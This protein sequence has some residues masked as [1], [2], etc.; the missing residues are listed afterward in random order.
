MKAVSL[1]LLVTLSVIG[2]FALFPARREI[3][4]QQR[5]QPGLAFTQT[6][7]VD[8]LERRALIYPNRAPAPQ[9]GTPMV[10]IFHGHGG[11]MRHSARRFAIHTHWPQAIVAYMQ[12]LPTAGKT[13]PEGKRA[14][15]QHQPDTLDNRDVKF[16][17]VVLDWARSNYRIDATRIYA[18]GHSNGAAMTYVLWSVRGEVLAAVAPSAAAFGFGVRSATPKPALIIAG[19]GDH[20]VPTNMQKLNM[21]AVLKRNQCEV[22]GEAWKVGQ[23]LY[24]SKVGADVATYVHTNG[25]K[26]PD[27]TG[28]TMVKF[29]QRYAL[30]PNRAG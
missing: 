30:K 26:M 6:F 14:G 3:R 19:E 1:S 28:V 16:F 12:G 24:S 21:A 8:G 9:T 11:N 23:T 15:W 5:S 27:D 25:H 29:F 10:F 13:D 20:L 4:A 18:G 22:N 17:D 7:T 2:L